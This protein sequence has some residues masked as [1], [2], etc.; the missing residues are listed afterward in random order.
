MPLRR[1]E[2]ARD[3]AKRDREARLRRLRRPCSSRTGTTWPGLGCTHVVVALAVTLPEIV[4]PPT[5]PHSWLSW[6]K[7][8]FASLAVRLGS[9][10]ATAQLRHPTRELEVLEEQRAEAHWVR[11]EVE[12]PPE[13]EEPEAAAPPEAEAEVA[14][15]GRRERTRPGRERRVSEPRAD[16]QGLKDGSAWHSQCGRGAA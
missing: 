16:S 12:L 1:W 4:P 13:E 15:R 14:C 2:A 9:P 10:F 7:S 8:E 11:P 6:L 3:R 5:R